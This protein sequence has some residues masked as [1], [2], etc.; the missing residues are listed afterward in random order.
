MI[1]MGC[2]AEA[3]LQTRAGRTCAKTHAFVIVRVVGEEVKTRL[4]DTERPTTTGAGVNNVSE[5]SPHSVPRP[6]ALL[7]KLEQACA[8]SPDP[9]RC[10]AEDALPEVEAESDDDDELISL[11]LETEEEAP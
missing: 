1:A 5:H 11:G 3:R 10:V 2:A 7:G 9:I 6:T 4:E 8:K